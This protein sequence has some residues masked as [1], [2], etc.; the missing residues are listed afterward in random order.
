MNLFFQLF[1]FNMTL[2]I[3]STFVLTHLLYQRCHAFSF[4]S[5]PI[6]PFLHFEAFVQSINLNLVYKFVVLASFSRCP[7]NQALASRRNY[8]NLTLDLCSGIPYISFLGARN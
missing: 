8:S 4:M 3:A 7:V 2:T 1:G 5:S 6:R